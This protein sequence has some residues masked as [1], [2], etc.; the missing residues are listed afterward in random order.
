MPAAFSARRIA[1]RAVEPLVTAAFG[2]SPNQKS[3]AAITTQQPSPIKTHAAVRGMPTN[4]TA[5]RITAIPNE[6][7][8]LACLRML[9]SYSDPATLQWGR[10]GQITPPHPTARIH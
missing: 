2:G 8:D 5:N 10:L 7:I 6:A 9:R 1:S 4:G 3:P